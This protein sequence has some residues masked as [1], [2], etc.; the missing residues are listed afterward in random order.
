MGASAQEKPLELSRPL[1]WK[2]MC[3]TDHRPVSKRPP[4]LPRS[5]TNAALQ[6][7]NSSANV[8][9]ALYIAMAHA[10]LAIAI[11]VLFGI[12]VLLR[13]YWEP[14]QWAVL[15]SMPLRELQGA[16]VSFWEEPLQ[17]GLLESIMA[18]PVAMFKAVVGTAS[19]LHN[20]VLGMISKRDTPPNKVGFAKIFLWLLSF[21]ICTIGYDLLGP[22]VLASTALVGLLLYAASTSLVPALLEMFPILSSSSDEK[23]HKFSTIAVTRSLVASLPRVVAIWLILAMIMGS[24]GGAVILSYKVGMETKDAI[25]IMK[26]HVQSNNY[27]EKIGLSQWIEENNVSQQIDAYWV[28]AY[29]TLMQQVDVFVEKNNLTEAAEVGKEFLRGASRK[30]T[31]IGAENETDAAALDIPSHPLV[32]RLQDIKA[33]LQNYDFG[34]AYI[35]LEAAMG[36]ALQLLQIGKEEFFE[37]AKQTLQKSSEVGKTVLVSGTNL[38]GRGFYFMLFLWNSLASGAAGVINFFA[39]SVIFFSVLYYLITSESGGVMNQIL[40][41][42]P[43]SD[44][45]RSRCATVLD[46]AVSSVLLATLKTAFFQATFTWL[47]F[48]WFRIHFVYT[49][50]LL[51]LVQS[52]VPLFPNW[53]ASLPAG[54]QLALEGRYVMALI[55]MLSH[56]YLMEYG[57]A[58]IHEEIPGHNEYITGL[59]IAGGMALFSPALEGA[60]MGPLIM[61]VL[62][63]AKNLYAEFVLG[64][65]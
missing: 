40:N 63:A 31:V 3:K 16:L 65:K 34:G 51:A 62:F 36:L 44:P 21:A 28:Q 46:H 5:R 41:M 50:T 35:E 60:I 61:T 20:A 9:L 48:R 53:V 39:Q 27:A 52:V 38:M 14:I 26:T 42:V 47:F 24:L 1:S 57:L 19:D 17:K 30:P 58:K 54:A 23:Q 55:L 12:G 64:T 8:Q 4:G 11:L 2:E 33:K 45:I 43:L 15:I 37:K 18:T 13:D 59:S 32:E 56:V 7:L 22:V 10:G 29:D 49:S 6:R 25:V